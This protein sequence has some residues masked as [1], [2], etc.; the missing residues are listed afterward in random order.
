MRPVFAGCLVV[1]VCF[2]AVSARAESSDAEV[3]ARIEQRLGQ[4]SA[5]GSRI[6]VAVAEGNVVLYGTV[7]VLEHAL[8]AEQAVWQTEGV[9]DV[10]NELRVV[11][12]AGG[13]DAA[14]EREVRSVLADE[15]FA[16]VEIRIEVEAGHVRLRGR[17]LDPVDVLALKHRIA[18]IEGVVSVELDALLVAAW[19]SAA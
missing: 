7:R 8:R 5:P 15:R 17:I 4:L 12:L 13:G 3:R 18:A 2:G 1:L 16:G 9:S 14:I 10:D 19:G 6:N 11:P